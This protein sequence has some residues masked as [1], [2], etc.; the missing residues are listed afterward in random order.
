MERLWWCKL[1]SVA[2][3]QE[4]T[5]KKSWFARLGDFTLPLPIMLSTSTELI[6]C[7]SAA[8]DDADER[9]P[10][11]TRWRPQRIQ[12]CCYHFEEHEQQKKEAVGDVT[13]CTSVSL[14]LWRWCRRGCRFCSF[15][16]SLFGCSLQC[17]Y[18]LIDTAPIS[19][20]LLQLQ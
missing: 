8:A 20:L 11:T 4:I 14:S 12:H 3:K 1:W 2:T 10:N 7:S 9:T 5:T 16:F 15:Q 19:L 17:G 6:G 18:F 13:L